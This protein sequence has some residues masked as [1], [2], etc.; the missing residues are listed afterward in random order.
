MKSVFPHMYDRPE[1][2]LPLLGG[3]YWGVCFML[4]PFVTTLLVR[5]IYLHLDVISW[6]DIACYGLN[7]LVMFGLFFRYLKDS[8]FNVRFHFKGF[9]IAVAISVGLMLLLSMRLF[10]WGLEQDLENVLCAYPIS[11]TS[12]LLPASVVVLKLPVPGMI[13]MVILAPVTVSC[14]FYG[15]VFAPVCTERRAM[16]YLAVAGALLLPRL[17]NGWWL[18]DWSY[19]LSIYFLQLPLHL[20]ACWA[21]QKADTIWAPIAAHSINNL[22]MCLFLLFLKASGHIG[23]R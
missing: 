9:V 2:G 18:G 12:V 19:E 11:E 23:V 21:Y 1:T 22:V 8:F 10:L 14:L 6:V 13:C 3:M 15:T 4:V 17:F 20:F 5:D 16:A 7:F